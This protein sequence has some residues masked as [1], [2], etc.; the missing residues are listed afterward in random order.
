MAD[1]SRTLPVVY[2]A[3]LRGMYG[4]IGSKA[5]TF[6]KRRNVT[7]VDALMGISEEAVLSEQGCGKGVWEVI[8]GAQAACLGGSMWQ[9]YAV[10]PL[11]C[12]SLA[13]Y[14]LSGWKKLNSCYEAANQRDI[15][16]TR[17]ALLNVEKRSALKDACQGLTRERAR[18][19]ESDINEELFSSGAAKELFREFYAGCEKVFSE[20]RGVLHEAELVAYLNR[21]FSWQGTT[22]LSVKRLAEYLGAPIE[23]DEFGEVAWNFDL[24]NQRYRSFVE[25][26]CKGLEESDFRYETVKQSIIAFGVNDLTLAEYNFYAR[27]MMDSQPLRDGSKV[28][29]RQILGRTFGE[30]CSDTALV[31][32]V[33]RKVLKK[34]DAP[35]ALTGME[36]LDACRDSKPELHWTIGRIVRA[37]KGVPLDSTGDQ[38][39]VY[40]EGSASGN[41]STYTLTSF[42]DDA[43]TRELI[44]AAANA[45]KFRLNETNEDSIEV[46]P[47]YD[48]F[49][50][51]FSKVLPIICFYELIR[52]M[53]S[54]V[55]ELKRYP[56]VRRVGQ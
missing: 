3:S 56:E 31:H 45:L 4:R 21:V 36:L 42:F 50:G 8:K 14:V 22:S 9:D 6:L 34:T 41:A 44:R 40:E 24:Q 16:K 2:M 13:E 43:Q 28:A 47:V 5:R 55:V 52:F 51:K 53:A 29:W 25:V 15:L 35:H 17:M 27:M 33:I 7:T 37:T 11:D 54:D 49:K 39:I 12:G 1:L 48:D 38:L 10:N 19:I 26:I 20:N 23:S 46:R 32:A 18:Q 30:K